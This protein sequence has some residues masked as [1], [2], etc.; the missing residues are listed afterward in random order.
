MDENEIT[1][2]VVRKDP[3]IKTFLEAANNQMN[4][5]GYTEHGFRHAGIVAN[6]ARN[7]ILSLGHNGRVA[8]L[9]AIAGYLHDIGNSINRLG[10][11]DTAALMAFSLLNEIG[12]PAHEIADIIAAIGNHE[13]ELGAPVSA[14]SAALIIADKSDVHHSRVQNQNP[15]TFDIHDRVNFSVQK[16]HLRVDTEN[17]TIKL[18]LT[19][20]EQSASVMEYF[21]IFLT[22]MLM[23]RRAADFFGY[24]FK[25]VING[26]E[27]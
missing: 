11:P 18:E 1:L 23:C 10:H 17:K 9:A 14:T 20:D 19:T 21:E 13:E 22:R 7:I 16:S 27:M 12:M 25:L 5:L 8:E 26:V 6:T 15:L 3:K 2:D 24:K 4:E